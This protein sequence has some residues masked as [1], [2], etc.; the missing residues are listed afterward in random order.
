MTKRK[1]PKAWTAY[2][3]AKVGKRLGTVYGETDKK[4]WANA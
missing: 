1:P 3:L 2:M 4:R